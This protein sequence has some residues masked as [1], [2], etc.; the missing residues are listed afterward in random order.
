M[1]GEAGSIV[2]VDLTTQNA[3]LVRDFYSKVAG[4]TSVDLAMD[5]YEDYIMMRNEEFPVAGICHAKGPNAKLPP[6]WLVYILVPDLDVSMAAV[7]RQGGEIVSGPTFAGEEG[8]KFCVIR[9]IAG[10]YCA[11]Y[12]P[13]DPKPE[14]PPEQ[15][16]PGAIDWRDICV[17]DAVAL[18]DFYAEVAGWTFEPVQMDGYEDFNM[19]DSAG[20]PVAGICHVRGINAAL[21]SDWLVYITVANL[22]EA[23]VALKEAG[24]NVIAGPHDFDAVKYC[25]VRDIAGAPFSLFQG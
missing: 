25:V 13:P 17:P 3:D 24:G 20:S 16:L 7:E 4:W 11:L 19:F 23:L 21:P 2:H 14:E 1:T 5:G 12:S 10:A 18:R 8:Q 22:D 15:S 6:R 9:D